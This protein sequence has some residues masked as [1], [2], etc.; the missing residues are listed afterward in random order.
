MPRTFHVD[1]HHEGRFWVIEI[2]AADAIT[3]A[4]RWDEIRPMAQDCA[5]LMLDVP[6]NRVR[7]GA[8]RQRSSDS[9]WRDAARHERNTTMPTFEFDVVIDRTPAG[10]DFD[11]LF[12]AGLDDTT[13][14]TRAGRGV[15]NVHRSAANLTAAIASIK[16]DVERAGFHVIEIN[17][18]EL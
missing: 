6:L 15:L 17:P 3:Q 18:A 11:R 13:P 10:D 1:V 12:D 9:F 14:E 2:P 4:Y 7:I 5:A 16:R 8:V